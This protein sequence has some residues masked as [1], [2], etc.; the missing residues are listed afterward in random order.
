MG[1]YNDEDNGSSCTEEMQVNP[2]YYGFIIGK[3][4]AN[5]KRIR[6]E[7]G[8]QIHI[9]D[10]DGG[11]RVRIEG[12]YASVQDAK[13]ELE[14]IVR[15]L[16]AKESGGGGGGGGG[17]RDGG[18]RDRGG[19]G[20]GR[21]RDG[22]GGGYGR[23][24][25]GF[26]RRDRDGGRD[27][28]REFGG[29]GGDRGG[30]RERPREFREGPNDVSIE[31]AV[32]KEYHRFIIGKNGATIKKIR[33]ETGTKIDLPSRDS[34]SDLIT[35]T[36]GKENVEAAKEQILNT[37]VQLDIDIDPSL[38]EFMKSD[39]D[40]NTIKDIEEEC[41]GIQVRF[42]REGFTGNR[43]FIRGPQDWVEKGKE[44]V[45]EFSKMAEENH[46]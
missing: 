21:D 20:G 42:P 24:D 29:R 33:D 8:A 17:G 35:I 27:G 18:G 6:D 37:E 40:G 14:D 23:N 2:R 32:N 10:R 38:H 1:D 13:H 36:G 31:V 12:S 43:I 16:D 15:S 9:P 26:D 41:G 22:G 46:G 11:N 28:Y 19:Y 4:G 30:F 34:D 45:I 3:S 44:R 39:N 7:T 25:R 5:I